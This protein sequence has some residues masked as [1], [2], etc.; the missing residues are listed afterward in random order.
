MEKEKVENTARRKTQ[1]LSIYYIQVPYAVY[2]FAILNSNILIFS[3][4]FAS[5]LFFLNIPYLSILFHAL[6]PHSSF[7]IFTLEMIWNH[8]KMIAFPIHLEQPLCPSLSLFL[9]FTLT[10]PTPS[11]SSETH[12]CCPQPFVWCHIGTGC[13]IVTNKQT[14]SLN[15]TPYI[16]LH[17]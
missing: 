16:C 17:K 4:V 1:R 6:P 2:Y 3:P 7:T 10:F 12:T 9:S 13:E 11:F 14:Q 15:A 5:P 8:T